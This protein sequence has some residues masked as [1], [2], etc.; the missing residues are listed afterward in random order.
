MKFELKKPNWISFVYLPFGF[1]ISI[2]T[3][4]HSLTNNEGYLWISYLM[5][6]IV[7]GPW[8]WLALVIHDLFG[9]DFDKYWKE[10][11][12][13]S[14]FINSILFYVLGCVVKKV[15]SKITND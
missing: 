12:Y 3:L 8:T 15:D 9:F 1:T 5:G 11:I 10:M 14:A 6:V 7:C 13:L 2:I 4:L